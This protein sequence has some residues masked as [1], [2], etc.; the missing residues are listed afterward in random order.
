MIWTTNLITPVVAC[1]SASQLCTCIFKI[2]QYFN[3]RGYLPTYVGAGG[4]LVGITTTHTVLVPSSIT[5]ILTVLSILC[6]GYL[7]AGGL[8]DSGQYHNCT[9]GSARIVDYW[10][11]GEQHM[12]SGNTAKVSIQVI[13]N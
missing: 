1:W 8:A 3:C 4:L 13:I 5:P 7:G 11:L 2:F 6:R 12:Y 10:I 9:G